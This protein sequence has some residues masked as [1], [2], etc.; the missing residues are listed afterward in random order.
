[1]V[2]GTPFKSRAL[3]LR[4]AA[5]SQAVCKPYLTVVRCAQRV[6]PPGRTL[7]APGPFSALAFPQPC[8]FSF[9]S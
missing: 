5:V 8:N 6:S 4:A 3:L 2:T 9:S 1:M 7:G